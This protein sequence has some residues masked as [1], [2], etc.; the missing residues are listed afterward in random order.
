MLSA[1]KASEVEQGF[2]VITRSILDGKPVNLDGQ[3]DRHRVG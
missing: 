2:Q 1:R 3:A